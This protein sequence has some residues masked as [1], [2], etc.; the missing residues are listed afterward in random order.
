MI[1]VG[2]FVSIIVYRVLLT[3]LT[4]FYNSS[5]ILFDRIRTF[6]SVH[7]SQIILIGIIVFVVFRVMYSIISNRVREVQYK[8]KRI[9]SERQKI[10]EFLNKDFRKMDLKILE[11][12]IN[13]FQEE[14]R[15]F[16][17]ESMYGYLRKV[18]IKF[19]DLKNFLVELKHKDEVEKIR[20]EKYQILKEIEDLKKEKQRIE[21]Y[22]EF[23]RR[24]ILEKLNIAEN[25]IFK[26]DKLK[27][28][29]IKILKDEKFKQINEYCVFDQKI[30]TVLIRRVLN[31]SYRH[32]FLV[33]SVRRLLNNSY[34]ITNIREHNTREADLTFNIGSKKYAIEIE[35]GSLLKKKDQLNR[36]IEFL[37]RKYKKRWIIL[38]SNRNSLKHYRKLGWCCQRK[39]MRE[40]LEKLLQI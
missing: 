32:I 22:K 18:D 37:K 13:N 23:R 25:D 21:N 20:G 36:K 38:V 24:D 40:S 28:E 19:T 34:E 31:H 3:P 10:E 2:A 35:T 4:E 8:K 15:K 39:D 6:F 27:K 30:I 26:L 1:I 5:I 17:E 11:R 9:A 29:E 16:W 12:Y 14:K 7:L 33:W